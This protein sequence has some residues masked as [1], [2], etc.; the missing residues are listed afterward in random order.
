MSRKIKVIHVIEHNRHAMEDWKTLGKF[1]ST[2]FFFFFRREII[3]INDVNSF[4]ILGSLK[5]RKQDQHL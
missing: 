4:D 5:L 3:V 1:N 2:T